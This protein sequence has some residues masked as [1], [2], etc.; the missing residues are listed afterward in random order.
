MSRA[1]DQDK[2]ERLVTLK[3]S[4]IHGSEKEGWKDWKNVCKIVSRGSGK[5]ERHDPR[6]EI[7]CFRPWRQSNFK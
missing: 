7:Q 4:H 2:V 6:G 3:K 5:N 1:T